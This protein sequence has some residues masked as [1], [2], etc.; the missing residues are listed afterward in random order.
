M[1]N[2]FRLSANIYQFLLILVIPLSL[3]AKFLVGAA[4]HNSESTI[5]DY[6]LIIYVIVALTSLIILKKPNIN[7]QSKTI[8]R[9]ILLVLILGSVF[10]ELYGLYNIYSLYINHQFQYGDNIPAIIIILLIILSSTLF[11][12][13]LKNKI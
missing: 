1:T 7:N 13:I 9:S 8:I 3:I 4:G 5:S 11:I 2:I 6:A 12:G 10:C